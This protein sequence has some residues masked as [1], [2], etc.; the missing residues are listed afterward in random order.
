MQ[1]VIC[2]L[3]QT[4]YTPSINVLSMN[5]AVSTLVHSKITEHAGS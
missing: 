1:K 2:P 5:K 4:K 3:S